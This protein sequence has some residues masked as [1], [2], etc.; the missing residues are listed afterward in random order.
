MRLSSNLRSFLS[1]SIIYTFLNLLNKAIPFVLFPLIVRMVSIEDFGL[2]SLF[3]TVESMLM[4]IVSLNIYAALS[5]HYYIDEINIRDYLSTIVF[6]EFFLILII[7]CLSYSIPSVVTNKLGLSNKF[8]SIA[9]FISGITGIITL[10]STLFRLERKPWA[11]GAYSIG[12]SITLLSAIIFFCK[13]QPSF[14]M[15]IFGRTTYALIF[16]VIS[17]LILHYSKFLTL[18]FN[19]VWF[20]RAIKF[21]LPTVLYSIS[22]FLFLSSDRFLIKYF[23]GTV[24][25]GH[26]SAIFQLASMISILGMSL[27]A[28]WIP[29]LFENLNKK[30]EATN[31]F[32]VKLSYTLMFGFLSAGLIFCVVYPFMAKVILPITYHPYINVAYPLIIGYVFEGV[33]LIVSPYVF[34]REKTK[35]NGLIGV[36][37]AIVNIMLN[38]LLIPILGIQ[39]AAYTVCATW[40]LLSTLFFIFS[41][42][43][44]PMPWLYFL[45]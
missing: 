19:K 28:A 25:V 10:I 9:I 20:L 30:D 37:V 5:S 42:K 36:L 45:S 11:Y 33:Y 21:S 44:H 29:W 4:P 6:T 23:Y 3:I 35:Y 40:L 38:I 34:Y 1:D 41:Y 22:A 12:Q 16:A 26:Y 13:W 14:D 43:V 17:L 32:I 7:V 8:L 24:E 27:N 15:L 18:T 39:G 31:I 2:Y